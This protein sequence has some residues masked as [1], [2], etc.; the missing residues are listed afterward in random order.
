MGNVSHSKSVPGTPNFWNHGPAVTYKQ[1]FMKR[2]AHDPIIRF[3]SLSACLSV[4]PS[5][6]SSICPSACLSVTMFYFYFFYELWAL[7][8]LPNHV[9]RVSHVSGLI[10]SS[11]HNIP[12]SDNHVLFIFVINLVVSQS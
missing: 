10:D 1:I 6:G 12:K 9:E 8:L 5:L 7:L 4:Q 2:P 11:R 3:V